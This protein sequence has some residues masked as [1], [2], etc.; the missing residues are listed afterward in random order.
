LLTAD[1]GN[2]RAQSA[3]TRAEL[4]HALVIISK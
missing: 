4:A 1:G 3:L 2:F